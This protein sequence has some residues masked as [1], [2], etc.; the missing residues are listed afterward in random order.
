LVHIHDGRLLNP[1]EI[2]AALSDIRKLT[3]GGIVN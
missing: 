2:E 3:E 1:E